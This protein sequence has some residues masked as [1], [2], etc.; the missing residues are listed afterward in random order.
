MFGNPFS[1]QNPLISQI[2][3]ELRGHLPDQWVAEIAMVL[4]CQL[5]YQTLDQLD[6][7]SLLKLKIGSEK[8]PTLCQCLNRIVQDTQSFSFPQ[9]PPQP[10]Y[11]SPNP[12]TPPNFESGNWGRFLP[13]NTD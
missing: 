12:N 10:D 11:R 3:R 9:E 7:E 6:T 4:E 2:R 5:T 1:Q 13:W 8:S